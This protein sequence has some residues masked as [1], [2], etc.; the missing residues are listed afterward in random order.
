MLLLRSLVPL[1]LL[2]PSAAGGQRP[3]LTGEYMEDRANHVFGCYCE[4]SGEGVTAGREAILGWS[5]QS[6]EYDA[7]SLAGAKFVLVIRGDQTLS[8]DGARRTS[9]LFVDSAATEA[10]AR[11]VERLVRRNYA[12]I[13]G[14][15][16]RVDRAPVSFVRT[17]DAAELRVGTQSVVVMRR[18]RL[19]EDALPGARDWYEPF[20]PMAETTLGTTIEDSYVGPGFDHRWTRFDQG[21]TGYFGTFT[22]QP[23]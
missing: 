14:Q 7:T 20:I 3:L 22:L 2:L 23:K 15:L 4:W 8:R 13:A 11:A 17:S 21:V 19:P 6:G 1:F 16:L 10:Q 12:D 9:V 5:V 18:A